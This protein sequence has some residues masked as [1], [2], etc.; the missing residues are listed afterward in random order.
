MFAEIT[1][2]VFAFAMPAVAVSLLAQIWLAWAQSV[3]RQAATS[4]SGCA[5][6][7]G[8]LD[9]AGLDHVRVEEIPGITSAY[10]DPR[11]Q[12]LQLSSDVY[13][14][15]NAT[16]IGTALHETGHALQ[17]GDR[18]PGSRLRSAAVVTAMYGTSASLV[19]AVIGMLAYQPPLWMT[20]VL[21]FGGAIYLQV[22]NLPLEWAATARARSRL[23]ETGMVGKDE[24]PVVN[25]VMNVSVIV[26]L[27]A[28]TQS[29]LTMP[30]SLLRRWKR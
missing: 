16:A 19:I 20:G 15:R 6:A 14:G 23:L 13:H 3:G 2:N 11:E 12:S 28:A 7:R 25:R 21:G 27:A 29:L 10:Y 24:L 4:L 26:L 5:A 8:V 1:D 17:V 18:G 30:L 22:V 9:A